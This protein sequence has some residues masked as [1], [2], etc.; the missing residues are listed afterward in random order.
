MVASTARQRKL[1]RPRTWAARFFA[2]S[3]LPARA[4]LRK[5]VDQ[6]MIEGEWIDG[7]CWV[8][9]DQRPPVSRQRNGDGQVVA[10]AAPDILAGYAAKLR[11]MQK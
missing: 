4:T 11:S 3:S 1:E 8:Y 7:E 6:G 5:W 2:E 9:D 10:Q